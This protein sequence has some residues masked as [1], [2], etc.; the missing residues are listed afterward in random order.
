MTFDAREHK[1]FFHDLTEDGFHIFSRKHAK[2]PNFYPNPFP[3]YPEVDLSEIKEGDR[4]TVRAFFAM[5]KTAMPQVDGGHIDLKV[6]HVDHD[7][8]TILGNIL[9][10]LPPTF[11][12]AKNTSIEVDF[13][14]VLSVQER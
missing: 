2:T 1:A 13:D 9:T 14:E 10:E 3:E 11:A 6:E 5:D 8:R 4:I 7:A 12:L